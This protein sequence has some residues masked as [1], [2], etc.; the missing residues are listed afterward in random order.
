LAAIDVDASWTEEEGPGCAELRLPVER[1]FR[2]QIGALLLLVLL[3]LVTQS[4]RIFAGKEFV[5]GLVPMFD[6]DAEAN[7]PSFFQ[8]Q[9]LLGCGVALAIVAVH[10]RACGAAQALRWLAL[11]LAFFYLGADEAAMLHDRM[12]P[13]AMQL[14]GQ[15][16]NHVDW[17]LP[18]GILAGGFG[19][20]ILPLLFAIPRPLARAFIGAGIV[21]LSGAVGFELVGKFAAESFGYGSLPYVATVALEEGGEMLGVALMLRAVLRHVAANGYALRLAAA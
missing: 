3:Y 17:M 11:S 4:L 18:M 21:Y 5:F 12:G 1:I 19:L 10:E 2:W 13:P 20:F 15:G 7:L 9:T 14:F 6:L 16:P 8:S